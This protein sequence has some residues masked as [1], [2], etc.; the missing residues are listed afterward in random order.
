MTL[1]DYRRLG[2]EALH[3]VREAG[4]ALQRQAV[5]EGGPAAPHGAVAR[6]GV[7]LVLL[8]LA[9]RRRATPE[10]APMAA[11][12]KIEKLRLGEKTKKDPKSC[13]SRGFEM[14]GETIIHES[15]IITAKRASQ[16]QTMTNPLDS[17]Y[18]LKTITLE[19]K[20]R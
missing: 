15:V 5:V 17:L 4:H 10:F 1:S 18:P 6:Q 14:L 19:E 7:E 8:G 16:R 11:G 12:N 2:S 13:G 3:E 20:T 9:R